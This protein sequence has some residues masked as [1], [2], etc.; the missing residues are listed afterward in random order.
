MSWT[1]KQHPIETAVEWVAPIPLALA[2]GWAGSRFGMSAV[3]T[4]ALG[5]AAFVFGFVAIRAGDGSRPAALHGFEPSEFEAISPGELILE[6]SDAVLE[7]TDRLEEPGPDSRV[8][9]LFAREEPTPGELVDRIAYFL[10]EGGRV[11]PPECTTAEN[12]RLPD[13]SAALQD[14]LANIRASLR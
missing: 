3:E 9:R 12:N 2:M 1:G 7:L 14:A 8:V 11:V 13:A 10:G 5:A 6:E 4:M